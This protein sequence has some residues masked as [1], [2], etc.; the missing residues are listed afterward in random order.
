M[1]GLGSMLSIFAIP[2]I[3]SETK[4]LHEEMEP[5]NFSLLMAIKRFNPSKVFKLYRFPQVFLSDLAC[6]F[7]AVTQYGILTSIRHVIN[8]RF[9]FTTPLFSGLFY[10]APGMGF[11]AGSLI[12]GR[13]SDHTV[14]RY[15][16]KRDGVRLPK[17]RLNSG[18]PYM[19]LLL[20]ISMLLYGW[21]LEKEFGGLALPVVL[22]FLIG[23]GLMGSWNGLNTYSAGLNNFSYSCK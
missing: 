8:P 4:Q 9:G 2:S 7:L 19:F 1:A 6:G 15:I 23:T 10:I 11:I 21:C 20:P 14:K 5:G 3:Q 18:L 13:L 22:A 16:A 17:D 12:G